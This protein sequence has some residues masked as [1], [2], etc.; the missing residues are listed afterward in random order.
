MNHIS[1]I[2]D[3]VKH[4]LGWRSLRAFVVSNPSGNLKSTSLI[5]T[6][7]RVFSLAISLKS[8][9][10]SLPNTLTNRSNI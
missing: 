7:G 5:E 6:L 2:N 10:T 3:I 1:N 4:T 8:G 9:L